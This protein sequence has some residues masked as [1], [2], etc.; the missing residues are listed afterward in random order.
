MSR[1]GEVQYSAGGAGLDEG[2]AE[3]E[4]DEGGY[5]PRN[6]PAGA[7][8]AEAPNGAQRG[9]GP[10]DLGGAAS[11]R[12]VDFSQDVEPVPEEEEEEGY[13]EGHRGYEEAWPREDGRQAYRGHGAGTHSRAPHAHMR[14]QGEFGQD[15]RRQGRKVYGQGQG[16]EYGARAKWGGVSRGSIE[17]EDEEEA[18]EPY[19]QV[20]PEDYDDTYSRPQV[21]PPALLGTFPLIYSSAA[22]RHFCNPCCPDRWLPSPCTL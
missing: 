11:W 3:W 12:D 20:P 22:W 15:G 7:H 18:E 16:E 4:E 2:E 10:R 8:S 6:A 19:R 9:G 17:E 13:E 5:P 14:S 1:R 21:N